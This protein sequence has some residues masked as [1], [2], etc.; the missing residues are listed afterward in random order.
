[1]S[2]TKKMAY[3]RAESV[4]GE[5][6]AFWVAQEEP[7]P[8][9]QEIALIKYMLAKAARDSM[10]P[11]VGDLVGKLAALTKVSQTLAVDSKSWIKPNDMAKYRDCFLDAIVAEYASNPAT[12]RRMK[13][14]RDY[15]AEYAEID[16]PSDVWDGACEGFF[17]SSLQWQDRVVNLAERLEANFRAYTDGDKLTNEP[18]PGQDG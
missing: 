13:E 6:L 7:G 5:E 12:V 10:Y 8:L 11:M 4:E 3:L 16:I 18:T 2:N 17:G 15:L 14:F 9:Q 1:M